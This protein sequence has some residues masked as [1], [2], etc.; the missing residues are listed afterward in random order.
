MNILLLKE[1]TAEFEPEVDQVVT[2]V[3]MTWPMMS[4]IDEESVKKS[5]P[6]DKQSKAKVRHTNQK[7]FSCNGI[8]I[9]FDI[10]RS[11]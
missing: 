9:W 7:I 5:V 3:P 8:F 11:K 6:E 1:G 10:L 2:S 4:E